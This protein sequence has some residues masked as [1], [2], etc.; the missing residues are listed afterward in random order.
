MSIPFLFYRLTIILI[1]QR[2]N[3]L[4]IGYSVRRGPM[5]SNQ[6]DIYF[7][8]FCST[9]IKIGAFVKNSFMENTKW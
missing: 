9:G 5:L 8:F 2:K 3:C 1:F 6:Y 4:R 7:L